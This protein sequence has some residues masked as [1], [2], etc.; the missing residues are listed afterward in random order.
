[1][2]SLR[3]FIACSDEKLRLA[4][5][6][7]LDK[8]PGIGVVG[9]SDRLTGLLR[10]LEGSEPDVLLL[11]WKSPVQ[12]LAATLGAFCKLERR[13]KTV[14]FSTRPEDEGAIK[15]AGADYFISKDAPPDELLP[16]LDDIRLSVDTFIHK[17]K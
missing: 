10:Q 8:E 4:L 2:G 12:S 17:E 14:V 7:F 9:L 11:D 5:I 1:M 15:A 6:M 16:I 13:P 3:V